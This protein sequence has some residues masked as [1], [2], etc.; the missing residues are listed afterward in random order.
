MKKSTLIALCVCIAGIGLMIAGF[1]LSKGNW[2]KMGMNSYNVVR[3][4]Y[5]CTTNIDNLKVN[6]SSD[7]VKIVRGDVDKPVVDYSETENWTYEIKESNGTLS[8]ERK[9]IKDVYFTFGINTE[10]T[11]LVI[12]LPKSTKGEFDITTSSGAIKITDINCEKMALETSSGSIKLEGIETGKFT[13]KATSGAIKITDTKTKDAAISASSG[14]IKVENLEADDVTVTTTSGSIHFDN[15]KAKG[16]NANATSGG[17]SFNNIDVSSLGLGAT[18]GSVKCDDTSIKDSIVAK[19]TSGS[20]S[21]NLNGKENDYSIDTS[22]TSGSCNVSD[23]T[24]G[25]KSI[26]ASATSGSI[27]IKFD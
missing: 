2:R 21:L 14:N 3:K 12:T 6:E 13:A 20:I 15:I 5:E 1:A 24:G 10:N 9:Q 8:I 19:T 11:D 23:R 17:I 7:E 16:V 26:K 27:T 25:S 18:S 22:T 4:T